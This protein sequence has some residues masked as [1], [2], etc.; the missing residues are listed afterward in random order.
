M[1]DADRFQAMMDTDAEALE[2][3]LNQDDVFNIRSQAVLTQLHKLADEGQEN[4]M[5][6]LEN[7]LQTNGYLDITDQKNLYCREK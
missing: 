1:S 3:G 7:F 4:A 5:Q 6:D 2:R